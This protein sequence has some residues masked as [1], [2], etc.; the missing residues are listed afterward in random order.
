M[1]QDKEYFDETFDAYSY[2][3]FENHLQ[4]LK[5]YVRSSRNPLSQIV[6]RLL[7]GTSSKLVLVIIK[8]FVL[9]QVHTETVG[10]Y[11]A[12]VITLK[13]LILVKEYHV[14]CTRN[15]QQKMFMKSLESQ[16]FLE[17][18]VLG[19]VHHSS[20][21]LLCKLHIKLFYIPYKEG[22]Y[23]YHFY[24]LNHFRPVIV[25]L[26]PKSFAPIQNYNQITLHCFAM[27]I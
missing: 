13:L 8:V 25:I 1:H 10:L 4:I 27:F 19:E 14:I 17:L 3:P 9:C 24:I 12:T 15:I 2:F 22:F 21:F 6:K 7:Q 11:I 26:L 23:W 20:T 5:Q 16:N 18:F